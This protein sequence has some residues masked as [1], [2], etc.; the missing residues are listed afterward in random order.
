MGEYLY[1][2]SNFWGLFRQ[3]LLGLGLALSPQCH[4]LSGSVTGSC[5]EAQ[6]NESEGN[7]KYF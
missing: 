1:V 2:Q 4:D 5:Q 7:L 6:Q 3:N